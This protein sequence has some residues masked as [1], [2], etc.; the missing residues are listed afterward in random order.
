MEVWPP[1]RI[2]KLCDTTPSTF[3]RRF[4]FLL[5]NIE[6]LLHEAHKAFFIGVLLCVQVCH[7]SKSTRHHTKSPRSLIN[8]LFN[9]V[10][11]RQVIQV[12]IRCLHVVTCKNTYRC[13]FI[14][15]S[16]MRKL[17]YRAMKGR[18]NCTHTPDSNLRSLTSTFPC[19]K[20]Q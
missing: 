13:I 6:H 12:T 17:F 19:R 5:T 3:D 8:I 10:T 2:V 16:W 15:S 4:C 1:F 7:T 9:K 20:V 14:M 11:S 18:V